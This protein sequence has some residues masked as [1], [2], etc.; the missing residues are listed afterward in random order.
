MS[1]TL[2]A[3]EGPGL[4]DT[5]VCERARRSRDAR[6]DGLFFTAVHSTGIYCRP[7]CPA[8]PPRPDNVSYLPRAASGDERGGGSRRSQAEHHAA[9][10]E[11]RDGCGHAVLLFS[12]VDQ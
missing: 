6:F 5:A 3:P 7:V 8:P 12:C 4:P 2:P 9:P 11:L 1:R 10:A